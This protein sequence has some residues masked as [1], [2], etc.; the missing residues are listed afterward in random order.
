MQEKKGK[1]NKLSIAIVSVLLLVVLLWTMVQYDFFSEKSVP[2][3]TEIS[4]LVVQYNKNCPLTIQEGIRLDSVS[5]PKEKVVQYN[6][7]LVKVEKTTAE[8][9]TIKENIEA[10]LV[11]TAKANPGLKTFREQNYTLIYDYSDKKKAHLFDVT[12][13]SDQYK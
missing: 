9:Q 3:N 4:E 10:S 11:S 1:N 2:V 12:I 7:T 5:L 8:I 13:T 6:L